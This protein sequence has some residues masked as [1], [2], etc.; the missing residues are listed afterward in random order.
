LET[1]R[2]EVLLCPCTVRF[3]NRLRHARWRLGGTRPDY[4]KY[5]PQGAAGNLL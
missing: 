1:S 3:N 5:H 4:P 2:L